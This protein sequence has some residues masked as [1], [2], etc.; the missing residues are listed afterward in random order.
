MTIKAVLFDLYGTLTYVENPVSEWEASEFLVRRGYEVY[1]QAYKAAWQFVSFI[2]YPRFG[3]KMWESYL[4]RVLE[5][6]GQKP[7][8]Q[9]LRELSKLYEKTTWKLYHDVESALI[10]TKDLGLKTAIVTTVARFKF[11]KAIEPVSDKI[12]LLVDG[13]TFRCE[14]S[15]SKIY[16]GTLKTLGV[17]AREAVMIGDDIQLDIM[18][19]KTIGMRAILLDR[20]GELSG[21]KC[22]GPDSIVNNL[23][24]ALDIIETWL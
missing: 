18:L 9:T 15:N 14:K 6:L 19:P 1:P 13:Y 5:L 8:D 3:Y 16:L 11:R 2:D 12:D 22:E 10:K 24:Q 7:D 23:N 17:R 20:K 4:K 21:E